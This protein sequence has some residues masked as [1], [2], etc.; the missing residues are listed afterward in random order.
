MKPDKPAKASELRRRAEEKLK[1]RR[2]ETR[3]GPAPH[4]LRRLLHELQVHQ[5]ELEMQNEELQRAHT[6][7]ETALE[8]Y[9]DLYDFAPTGYFTLTSDGTIRA[10]NLTGASLVG[11][12]R[13]QLVNRGFSLLVSK[14]SRPD[15]IDFLTRIFVSDRR[16]FCELA[17][18]RDSLPSLVVRVEGTIDEG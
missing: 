14:A 4:D 11:V 8:K 5:S 2:A 3:D 10:V 1:N 9:T 17:L 18:V 6:E 12:E 16:E 13:S 7:I 15:F